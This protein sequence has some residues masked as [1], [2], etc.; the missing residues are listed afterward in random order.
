M[1]EKSV[2]IPKKENIFRFP[3]LVV[4]FYLTNFRFAVALSMLKTQNVSLFIYFF[5]ATAEL[6]YPHA[7]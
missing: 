7:L 1:E 6:F 3:I 2:K 5:F 4:S